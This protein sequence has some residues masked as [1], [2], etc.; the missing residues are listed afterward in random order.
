MKRLLLV[1]PLLL[2]SL[3]AESGP[4]EDAK[5]QGLVGE[6][7]DG[8]IGAPPGATSSGS[9]I[10]TINAKRRQAYGEIAARN[11]TSI[12][13][14]GILTAQKLIDQ[15]PSGSWVMDAHGVWHRK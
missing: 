3:P 10:E 1:L 13:D 5:R 15:S 8:Y 12:H 7:A 11:G 9:L 2:I 4:L 14:V 6:R